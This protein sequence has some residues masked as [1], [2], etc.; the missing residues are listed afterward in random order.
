MEKYNDDFFNGMQDG[1]LC[2][3]EIMLPGVLACFRPGAIKSVVDFGCGIAEWLSVFQRLGIADVLGLDGAWVNKKLL[4]IDEKNFRTTDLSKKVLL[5][6]KYDLAVSMEVGEH[7]PE[8]SAAAFVESIAHAADFVLFSAAVPFQGGVNHINEQCPCYWQA[9]FSL[10]NFAAIDVLRKKVWNN[11]SVTNCYA[12]NT[13][14]YI[15][16]DRVSELAF[17]YRDS[18]WGGNTIY[19]ISNSSLASY[20]TQET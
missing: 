16:N 13:I 20:K 12:Q 6:K 2:S 15:K 1:S 18:T 8:T 5:E 4:K 10:H 19:S 3:A 14:L 17:D 9:L 7:L 11:V